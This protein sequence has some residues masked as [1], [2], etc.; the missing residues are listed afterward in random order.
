MHTHV[1]VERH[2]ILNRRLVVPSAQHGVPG[3]VGKPEHP[4]RRHIAPRH[5]SGHKIR[6]QYHFSVLVQ[7][8]MLVCQIRL[9]IGVAD[10]V[11]TLTQPL[12]LYSGSLSVT[13]PFRINSIS[14]AVSAFLSVFQP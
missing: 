12:Q 7:I 11:L 1:S 10:V 5:I 14:A 6:L 13:V 8:Q 2:P 4:R 3:L 9:H